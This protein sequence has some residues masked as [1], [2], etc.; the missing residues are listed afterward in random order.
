[1]SEGV[2]ES[3]P[4]TSEPAKV[5]AQ[6]PAER[7]FRRLEASRDAAIE[8][9]ARAEAELA[10]KRAAEDYARAN[11]QPDRHPLDGVDYAEPQHIKAALAYESKSNRREAE[12]IASEMFEK[13]DR[14][15][16][17]K[18]FLR[19][20]K[21]DYRDY[22][23]VVTEEAV[24]ELKRSAPAMLRSISKSD[25]P[26]EAGEAIYEAIKARAPKSAEKSVQQKVSDNQTNGYFVPPGYGTA[27][28]IHTS[29]QDFNPRNPQHAEK[30]KEMYRKLVELKNRGF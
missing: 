26:Y 6:S 5:E 24:E 28:Q 20:L 11:S 10:A 23:S 16:K 9:A 2:K 27:P 15:Q 30:G 21:R 29:A 3:E 13:R 25:D 8:R 14:E 22:D 18:N 7:N 4:A 12:R 19:D 1:M 17:Q